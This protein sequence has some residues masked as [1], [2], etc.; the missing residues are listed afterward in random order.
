MMYLKAWLFFVITTFA[1]WSILAIAVVY[2]LVLVLG[3]L[4]L[5][6]EDGRLVGV[7]LGWIIGAAT[8]FFCY[9]WSVRLFIL[10]RPRP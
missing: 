9:M 10:P 8:S 1:V 5:P 7:V 6:K 3:L 4:D 2:S